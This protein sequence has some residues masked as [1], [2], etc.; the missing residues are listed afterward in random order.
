MLLGKKTDFTAMRAWKLLQQVDDLE[1]EGVVFPNLHGFLN[2]AAFA[3][4]GNFELVPEN[5]SLSPIYLHS[6]FMLPLRHTVR[7]ALDRHASMA[8]DASHGSASS[9]KQRAVILAK[10]KVDRSSS[11]LDIGLIENFW[12]ASRSPLDP[13]GSD[14]TSFRKPGGIMES[15]LACWT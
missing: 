13:G 8:P 14:A 10:R 1:V 6:D 5:M 7:T 2:L 12:P 15:Y 9:V 11:V 3:Y 4:Y